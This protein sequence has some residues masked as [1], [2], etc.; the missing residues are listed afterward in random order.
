M[1]PQYCIYDAAINYL[2]YVM[3]NFWRH[4]PVEWACIIYFKK[5]RIGLFSLY[6][7]TEC[8]SIL[9]KLRAGLLQ[10]EK[11]FRNKN[12][13]YSKQGVFDKRWK[14]KKAL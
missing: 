7:W 2:S 11:S 9:P 12:E 5:I 14:P 4:R 13:K 3:L 10:G 6:E 1:E 8:W